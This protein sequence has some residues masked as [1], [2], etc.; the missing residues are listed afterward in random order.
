MKKANFG[1]LILVTLLVFS[2]IVVA[3]VADK[4]RVYVKGN[5]ISRT[6]AKGLVE[7]RHEFRESFSVEVTASEI[8]LL[9]AIPGIEI[10]EVPVYHITAPPFT[11]CG[12]GECQGWETPE[13]CPE[14]CGGSVECYP[15]SEYP[16]GIQKVNGGSGGSG[17]VVAVLD[18]GVDQDH[19]DLAGRIVGCYATGYLSCED[20]HGH[21]TH[22][23]GTV[24]ANGKIKGVA[25]EAELMAVKVCSDSGYCYDDDVADGI[26]YAVDNGANIISMSFGGTSISTIEYDAL[27]YA[28][29]NNVL[30]VAAAGN[31]GPGLDTIEYP[32]AYYKVMAVAAVDVS[33]N[34]ASFSSRGLS[35]GDY[36]VDERELDVAAPGV[37]VESTYN[38][39]CYAYMSGTSMATPHISGLAAKLWTGS[40]EST[41]NVID[42]NIT[43]DL[44][45]VGHDIYTG[46]G[47]PI[48]PACTADSD[49]GLGE[50][51][52]S[53]QCR[54]A[55]CDYGLDCDDGNACTIDTCNFAGTCEAICSYADITECLGGDG[56]C[57]AG[58]DYGTDSDCSATVCGNGV[59]E[60][61]GEDCFSCSS[62]CACVGR[63]CTRACCG[64]G[65]IQEMDYKKCQIY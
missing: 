64:D 63:D 57:P 7:A 30:L 2:L 65:V 38:N 60:G 51:C 49:C 18:T 14:D 48:I 3:S 31:S 17:V 19:P 11:K 6:I 16:W 21:G 37:S 36:I 33:E 15:D 4:Q 29:S 52:C 26:I 10:E 12:D 41:R 50:L 5:P 39:G 56:C 61:S 40:A 59:C 46:F 55:A 25:P 44:Y 20:G 35:D 54:V 58:C 28:A 45:T 62:D 13:T 32:G 53:G 24:L 1:V 34:V 8:A 47:L 43:K 23:A 9:K 27:D 42:Y 22:V